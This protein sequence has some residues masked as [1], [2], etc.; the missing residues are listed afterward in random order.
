MRKG[1]YDLSNHFDGTYVIDLYKYGPVY[2]EEFKKRFYMQV[3]VNPNGYLFT[4]TIIDSYIDYII[5]HNPAD[6]EKIG[7]VGQ[8]TGNVEKI[9]V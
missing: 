4:A 7:F 3:H 9:I 5:R 8:K 6:F 1:L 2:D